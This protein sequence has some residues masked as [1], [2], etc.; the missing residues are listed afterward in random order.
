MM[1]SANEGWTKPKAPEEDDYSFD[2]DKVWQYMMSTKPDQAELSKLNEEFVQYNRPLNIDELC[3]VS[4]ATAGYDAEHSLFSSEEYE[5]YF[6]QYFEK[7]CA[8]RNKC[9]IDINRNRVADPDPEF[10]VFDDF[11]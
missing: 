11:K 6:F 8:F 7:K 9:E 2:D 1:V 3:H 4:S 5:K 10:F